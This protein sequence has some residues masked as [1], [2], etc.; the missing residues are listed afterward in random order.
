MLS[1]GIHDMLAKTDMN[2][3]TNRTKITPTALFWCLILKQTLFLIP[4]QKRNAL[5]LALHY[6]NY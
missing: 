5:L 2:Y 4:L 6:Y 3:G 1:Q